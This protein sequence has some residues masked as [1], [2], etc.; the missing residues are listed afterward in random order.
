MFDQGASSASKITP[1][2]KVE[3]PVTTLDNI[4][5]NRPVTFI[6]MDIEGGEIDA[7]NGSRNIINEQKPVLAICVYHKFNDI[8]DIPLLIKS[9]G[10]NYK[11]Y[12]R[13]YSNYVSETVLYAV[14]I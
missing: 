11:Y 13:H 12:L 3:I 9:F 10:I 4:L 2:G 1:S 8:F 5:K 14:P 6:K 7:L